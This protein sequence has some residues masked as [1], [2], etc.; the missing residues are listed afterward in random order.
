MLS[1]PLHY[2]T[3]SYLQC[4]HYLSQIPQPAT[5]LHVQTGVHRIL[6]PREHVTTQTAKF[7]LGD[8]ILIIV[9]LL[10]SL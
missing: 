1:F 10:I 5:L 7:N 8:Q 4:S 9:Y 2:F 6:W 3:P